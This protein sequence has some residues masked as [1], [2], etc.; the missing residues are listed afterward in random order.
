MKKSKKL[1]S[2][3]TG[4][5]QGLSTATARRCIGPNGSGRARRVQK[6]QRCTLALALDMCERG[7][8]GY[9]AVQWYTSGEH[10][11]RFRRLGSDG[12]AAEAPAED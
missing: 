9:A 12:A 11:G 8:L 7:G 2:K 1:H 6:W 3:V 5:L 4:G 10:R